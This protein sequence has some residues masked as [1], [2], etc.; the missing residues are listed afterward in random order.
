MFVET[1]QEIAGIKAKFRI[2]LRYGRARSWVDFQT[3]ASRVTNGSG[4]VFLPVAHRRDFNYRDF[5]LDW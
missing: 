3:I 1:K 5:V 4:F 2:F